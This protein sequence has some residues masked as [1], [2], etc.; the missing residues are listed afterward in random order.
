[1]KELTGVIEKLNIFM[2]GMLWILWCAIHSVMI[3]LTVTGYLKRRLGSHFRFYRL[4]FNLVALST[5]VP[6]VLLEHSLQGAILFRW[7]GFMIVFQILLLTLSGLLFVAGA[8]HYDLFQFLGFRQIQT[9]S[10]HNVLTEAGNLDTR[11]I[12]DIIRHPWYLGAILLVWVRDLDTSTLITNIILT[13]YLIVGTVLEERKLI[14]AY[15]DDYRQYQKRVSMLF[16]LKWILSKIRR[17]SF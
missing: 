14:M 1:M 15:G 10:S 6:V 8:R 16:P 11:G 5:V 2:L 4:S 7:Q 13:T 17:G 12:L 3:S 9:G